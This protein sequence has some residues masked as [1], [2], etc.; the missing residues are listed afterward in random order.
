MQFF[1]AR[2]LGMMPSTK[3]VYRSISLLWLLVLTGCAADWYEAK[4]AAERE[5]QAQLRDAFYDWHRGAWRETCFTAPTPLTERACLAN[6]NRTLASLRGQ[7]ATR[8]DHYRVQLLMAQAVDE[9]V[10]LEARSAAV[11]WLRGPRTLACRK[12]PTQDVTRQCLEGIEADVAHWLDPEFPADSAE[13]RAE[14]AVS[15]I[16][17]REREQAIERQRAHELDLA[18]TQAAGQAALGF[19]IGGGFLNGLRNAT[20]PEPVYQSQPTRVR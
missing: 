7:Y 4:M 19:G 20:A 12:A 5:Q 9:V 2:R 13:V 6:G 16:E 17:A 14:R 15:R 11:E 3:S 8:E 1:H 18:R 10:S